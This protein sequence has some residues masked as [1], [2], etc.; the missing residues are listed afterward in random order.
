MKS[1]DVYRLVACIARILP[2]LA[3]AVLFSLF[4]EGAKSAEIA[5]PPASAAAGV[6]A[7]KLLDMS[8][9]RA[10]VCE[11]PRAGDGTLTLALAQ[12]SQFIV[13]AMESDPQRLATAR[14]KAARPVCWDGRF[15]W[16]GG[17]WMRCRWPTITWIFCHFR[18][19]RCRPDRDVGR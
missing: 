14:R 15:T 1:A 12:E 17:E 3:V 19:H 5:R 18:P 16:N 9:I 6:L 11:M 13:H 7:R 10:G 2:C 8:E 4:G